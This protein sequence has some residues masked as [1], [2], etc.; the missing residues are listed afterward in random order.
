MRIDCIYVT[1]MH[2]CMMKDTTALS[3]EILIKVRVSTL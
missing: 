3:D 2:A 1:T